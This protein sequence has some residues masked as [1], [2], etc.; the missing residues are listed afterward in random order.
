MKRPKIQNDAPRAVD[1]HVLATLVNGITDV[2]D[3]AIV[4]LFIYSG[5]RLDELRQLDKT[6]IVT[7]KKTMPDGRKESYGYGA[8]VGKGRKHRNFIV[9]PAA[10]NALGTYIR[11]CRRAADD[12]PALF[13]SSRQARISSRAIQYIVAKWCKRLGITH[14]H[15]HQL[16]HSFATRSV[17]AGMS[18]V[19]LQ[20]LLGHESL[21]T[22]Q[23]YFRIK[24]QRLSREYFSVMEFVRETSPV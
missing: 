2:R 10:V 13:L 14:I 8:V 20:A 5:L 1:D 19:A 11:E 18:A 9:G 7:R 6:T 4:L 17:N 21:G 15:I 24:P 23:R 16:R 22:T 3:K 12:K